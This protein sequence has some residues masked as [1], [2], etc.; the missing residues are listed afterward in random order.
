MKL[1]DLIAGYHGVQT[2]DGSKYIVAYSSYSEKN[3]LL[4]ATSFMHLERFNDDFTQYEHSDLD[5]V[6]VYTL[7]EDPISQSNND[8]ND[9]VWE[10]SSK[11]G[12]ESRL[13]EAVDKLD[14]RKNRVNEAQKEVAS[15]KKQLNEIEE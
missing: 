7:R 11:Q 15:I 13:K 2:R 9:L 1:S 6:K 10:E 3:Y 4:G 14:A 8:N 12:L 5:I